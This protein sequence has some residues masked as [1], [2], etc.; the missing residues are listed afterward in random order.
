MI[1]IIEPFGGILRSPLL[2]FFFGWD[3]PD[4]PTFDRF[5]S[6]KLGRFRDEMAT[7]RFNPDVD[8][9]F[10]AAARPEDQS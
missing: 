7:G 1:L 3:T 9:I 5:D 2:G 4:V 10:E 6:T 8:G